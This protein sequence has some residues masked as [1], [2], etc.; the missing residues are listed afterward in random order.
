M[1]SCDKTLSWHLVNPYVIVHNF[2]LYRQIW[3]TLYWHS[4]QIEAV[5]FPECDCLQHVTQ[6]RLKVRLNYIYTNIPLAIIWFSLLHVHV[7]V[8]VHV[9]LNQINTCRYKQINKLKKKNICIWTLLIGYTIKS[10]VKALGLYNFIRG[11]GW[12]Y[13]NEGGGLGKRDKTYQR[14][15]LKLTYHYI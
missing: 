5:H 2:I 8:H 11:F 10:H 13:I 7:H 9:Y 14:N 4:T 3:I 12:A 6:H 1:F 15:E